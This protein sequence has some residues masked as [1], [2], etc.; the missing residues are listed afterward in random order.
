MTM[1][2]R[3]A[4]QPAR[5]WA[6]CLVLLAW[7]LCWPA[8][9]AA[10]PPSRVADFGDNPGELA[11]Y[12]QPPSGGQS[13]VMVVL[14]HGCGQQAPAFARQ[15]GWLALADELGFGLVMPQQLAA[16]NQ[17]LCFNWY[18]EQ[19]IRRLGSELASINAMISYAGQR[20]QAERIYIAGLSAGGAMTAA[21][22]ATYPERFEAGAVIAGVAYRCGM[23]LLEA[24][25]CM[26]QGSGLSAAELAGLIAPGKQLASV[27]WP[28]LSIWHGEADAVV[29]VANAHALK[30]QWLGLKQLSET[31]NNELKQGPWSRS[32]WLRGDSVALELNLVADMNHGHPIDARRAGETA[33][34][35]LDQGIATAR[36]IARFFGLLSTNS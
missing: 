33:P 3:M 22:L 36:E 34:F 10:N 28:R 25:G 1:Q 19:D 7:I 13:P 35:V 9:Q 21:M 30:R 23:G 16:N 12:Y 2:R 15:S 4:R 5:R 18:R 24:F 14:L 8:A 27:D 26:Q 11:L 17:K 6:G 29:N 32:Q 20:Q 31:A